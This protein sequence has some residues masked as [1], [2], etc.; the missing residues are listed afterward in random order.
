MDDR[1]HG[2]FMSTWESNVKM[3]RKG[4]NKTW[5]W[6]CQVDESGSGLKSGKDFVQMVKKL[7][8]RFNVYYY[9]NI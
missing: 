4:M 7:T 2:E 8:Q 5:R 1:C 6:M 3:D 9:T